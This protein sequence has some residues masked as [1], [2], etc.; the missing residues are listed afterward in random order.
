MAKAGVMVRE[1]H[2]QQKPRAVRAMAKPRQ[3]TER[4]GIVIAEPPPGIE[5][6][7]YA[8][9]EAR[10]IVSGTLPALIAA[11]LSRN[12]PS[13]QRANASRSTTRSTARL[14]FR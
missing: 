3:P 7:T 2:V 5:P 4:D 12:A 6:G 8:L 14:A 13:A 1:A 11:H 9:R 10:E